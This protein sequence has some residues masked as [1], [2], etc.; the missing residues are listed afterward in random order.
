MT[1]SDLFLRR[2]TQV[3]LVWSSIKVIN[4]FVF[5]VFVI[6]DGTQISEKGW[7]DLQGLRQN[8]YEYA[9]EIDR[10]HI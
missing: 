6:L 9:S 8:Q 7:N 4:H 3:T 1:A 10:F 5:T 2:K